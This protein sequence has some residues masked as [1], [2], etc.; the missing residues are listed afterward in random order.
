[1]PIEL[2]LSCLLQLSGFRDRL[3]MTTSIYM[4]NRSYLNRTGEC[5]SGVRCFTT[6]LKT[7]GVTR[8]NRTLVCRVT[9]C[10][11]IHCPI[12][13]VPVTGFE[14]AKKRIRSPLPYP[15]G[16]TGIKDFDGNRT[17]IP[18]VAVQSLNRLATKS[19]I[20]L[21]NG[22]GPLVSRL[23]DECSNQLSYIR[24]TP[25]V[26]SGRER[27][28]KWIPIAMREGFEPPCR[29]NRLRGSSS[30]QLPILSTHRNF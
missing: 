13:T 16:N 28:S 26:S 21:M 22:F 15:L 8:G 1:M 12:V 20:V 29:Y 6:K 27:L 4:H 5:E 25:P 10:R 19:Y 2:K 7:Y 17:H 3:F 11:T 30:V 9:I 14:P 23:S 18:G 24:V